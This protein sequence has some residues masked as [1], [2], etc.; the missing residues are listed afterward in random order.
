MESERGEFQLRDECAVKWQIISWMEL[1]EWTVLVDWHS[2]SR[3]LLL[4]Y[5]YLP[6]HELFGIA[7]PIGQI[8][9]PRGHWIICN[10]LYDY[11]MRMRERG[12]RSA[13]SFSFFSYCFLWIIITI[14]ETVTDSATKF[15]GSSQ[16]LWNVSLFS[17]TRWSHL[18]VCVCVGD[19]LLHVFFENN[20]H[21]KR[22]CCGHS[23]VGAM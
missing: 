18:C 3:R 19:F 22:Q 21:S 16:L 8:R 9:I 13:F 2:L 1:V 4:F 23:D 15:T 14:R 12:Q 17:F 11:S 20:W 10:A 5:L 7:R 6:S